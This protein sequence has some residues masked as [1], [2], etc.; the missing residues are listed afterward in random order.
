MLWQQSQPTERG[1]TIANLQ[2]QIKRI[3][4][5]FYAV[6]SQSG[7]RRICGTK[8]DGNGY[9]ECPDNKYRHVKCKHIFAVELS[10]YHSSEGSSRKIEP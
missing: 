1:Q 5:V 7:K 10:T 6:K 8:I 2:G 4:D 3:D 9:C